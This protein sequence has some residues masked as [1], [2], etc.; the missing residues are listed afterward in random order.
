MLIRLNVDKVRV[1]MRLWGCHRVAV[2]GL[3]QQGPSW[4]PTSSPVSPTLYV[5]SV[6]H[7]GDQFESWKFYY[8]CKKRLPEFSPGLRFNVELGKYCE[9]WAKVRNLP[10]CL[11]F[12]GRDV[13]T[14]DDAS[15]RNFK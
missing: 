12:L 6:G 7:E 11:P 13:I 5:I 4:G 3:G 10:G 1:D 2:T 14:A 8:I 15:R 9:K